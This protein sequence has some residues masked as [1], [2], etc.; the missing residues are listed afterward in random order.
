MVARPVQL[1]VF[2]ERARGALN[3]R[4]FSLPEKVDQSAEVRRPLALA[5]AFWKR[6]E[7]ATEVGVQAAPPAHPR[8]EFPF[9]FARLIVYDEPPTHAPA[10]PVVVR[11]PL[12]V[13]EEVAVW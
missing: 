10:V 5:L 3:V 4:T 7:V 1:T 13:G 2:A 8:R 11:P 12:K 9:T 6:D